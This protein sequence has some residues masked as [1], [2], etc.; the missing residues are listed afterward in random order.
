MF[1]NWSKK[2]CQPS[3]HFNSMF[4]KCCGK[5]DDMCYSVKHKF[6]SITKCSYKFGQMASGNDGWENF[7]KLLCASKFMQ[8]IISIDSQ[9]F[10]EECSTIQVVNFEHMFQLAGWWIFCLFIWFRLI[11]TR[12]F[13]FYQIKHTPINWHGQCVWITQ[14]AY[15]LTYIR[16]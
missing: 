10:I 12:S 13:A 2:Q 9:K 14:T 16:V 4:S 8:F 15:V 7:M 11:F 5:I 1:T 3:K 6:I